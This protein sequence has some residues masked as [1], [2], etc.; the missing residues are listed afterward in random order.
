MKLIR[1]FD[2]ATYARLHH[3]AES[4]DSTPRLSPVQRQELAALLKDSAT[5]RD[6]SALAALGDRVRLVSPRDP[7]DWYEFELVLPADA[8]ID[9]DRISLFTPVGLAVLGRKCGDSVAW[10]VPAGMRE[11]TIAAVAKPLLTGG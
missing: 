4:S 3:L 8:D 10:E 2:E 9:A 5:T 7:D 6:T 1:F 11:M